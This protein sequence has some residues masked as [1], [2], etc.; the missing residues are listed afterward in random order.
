VGPESA[1][2]AILVSHG[3]QQA[4]DRG[5]VAVA[6]AAQPAADIRVQVGRADDHQAQAVGRDHLLAA[7]VVQRTLR[8]AV[9]AADGEPVGL[10]EER[11]RLLVLPLAVLHHQPVARPESVHRKPRPPSCLTGVSEQPREPVLPVSRLL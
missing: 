5:Q 1:H 3:M 10:V 9:H 11:H 4:P 2:H 7:G 8:A 6:A